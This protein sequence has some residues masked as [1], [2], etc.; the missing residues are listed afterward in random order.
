MGKILVVEDDNFFRDSLAAY[1]KERGH[2]VHPAPNGRVARDICGV[3]RFD[4]IL[5][6]IRMPHLDGVE[7]LKWVKSSCP[8]PFVLMTGFTNILETQSAYEIG[9]DD[10]IAKPFKNAEL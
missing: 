4:V 3:Q 1:M 8:M 9:A 2:E 6:D 7:L 5:S 10:F